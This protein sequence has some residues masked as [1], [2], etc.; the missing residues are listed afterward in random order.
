MYPCNRTVHTMIRENKR[1][2]TCAAIYMNKNNPTLDMYTHSR[3]TITAALKVNACNS[4]GC[5]I[6]TGAGLL[7]AV[8]GSE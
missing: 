7:G 6:C 3:Y 2:R 8:Q 5:A 1:K 4:C